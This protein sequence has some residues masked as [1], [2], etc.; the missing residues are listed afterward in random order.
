MIGAGDDGSGRLWA[1]RIRYAFLTGQPPFRSDDVL[2][3]MLLVRERDPEPP[4]RR[5]RLVGRDLAAICLKCLEK[6]PQT[7]LRLCRGAGEGFEA[8]LA[9]E[10]IL[11][12]P[13]G[14]TARLW[15]WCRRKPQVAGPLFAA[16]ILLLLVLVGLPIGM[17][18]IWCAR[19]NTETARQQEMEHRQRAESSY[20]LAQGTLL[21]VVDQVTL[22]P[23]FRG[24][25]QD[26]LKRAVREDAKAFYEKFL[27]LQGDHPGFQ[28]ERA[29]AYMQLGF[30]SHALGSSEEGVAHFRQALAISA[31]LAA[32]D[33]DV[34]EYQHALWLG[35]NNL[36]E[37]LRQVGRTAEAEQPL[38]E[39]VALSKN[40]V[41]DQPGSSTRLF[42]LGHAQNN[43]GLLYCET[44]RLDEAWR[45]FS[46]ALGVLHDACG[47]E[48]TDLGYLTELARTEMNFGLLFAQY[49]Q[50]LK[51]AR[52]P[53][54]DCLAHSRILA[55]KDPNPPEALNATGLCSEQPWGML[56]GGRATAAS[57]EAAQGSRRGAVRPDQGTPPRGR[58]SKPPGPNAV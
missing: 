13:I 50:N 5:N 32:D 37:I 18:L 42:E 22:D 17:Y 26:D 33:P 9:G 46:A 43:L 52:R 53:F 8:Y 48:P 51:A 3:T 16:F 28:L 27:E 11:A 21:Q 44:D 39:C 29:R 56:F 2:E 45:T 15:R 35:Y 55:E 14:R 24:S 10:P 38:L 41:R 40:A 30:I 31:K 36:G 34:P 47:K 7:A 12:R 4:D 23:R 57:G 1:R 19:Q 25:S 54:E 6:I 58:I 20:R 49:H